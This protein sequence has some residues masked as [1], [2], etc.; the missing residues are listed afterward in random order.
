VNKICNEVKKGFNKQSDKCDSVSKDIT[1]L[2]FSQ[3]IEKVIMYVMK[4]STSDSF[5]QIINENF[6]DLGWDMA[7]L[8]TL[9]E[10]Y[11]S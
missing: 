9:G 3:D 2:Y 5:M 7:G 1:K 6:I 4:F 11:G 8:E 10:N